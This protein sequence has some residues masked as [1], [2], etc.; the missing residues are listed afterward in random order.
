VRSSNSLGN[1]SEWFS[2]AVDLGGGR[3]SAARATS[4]DPMLG[5]IAVPISGL[6]GLGHVTLSV[7]LYS[8][9]KRKG[10]AKLFAR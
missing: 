5:Q 9:L 3:G 8:H 6:Q 10:L 1:T 7:P 2:Q 4:G